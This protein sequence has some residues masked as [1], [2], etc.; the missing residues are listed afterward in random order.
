M[1]VAKYK[2]PLLLIP[3]LSVMDRYIITELIPPFLFGMG[4]FSAVGVTIG[5][6]FDLMRRAVDEGL[7]ATLVL[8]VLVLSLPQFI[9]YAFPTSILLAT[10]LTYSRLSSDSELTALRSCGVS[11]YRLVLPG[12]LLSLLVTGLTFL[13]NEQIVPAANYQATVTMERAL[14]E[15]KP[16][17]K[18]RNIFY[19]EYDS[20]DQEGNKETI[21]KRLF[22]A[23]QFDGERMRGLTI[24]DWSQQGL[25]QIVTAESAVWNFT[26]STWDFF[27]G[28]IYLIA[29]DASYR[30]ILR[31]THQQLQLPRTPLDLANKGRDYDEMNI[32]ESRERLKLERASGDED[33]VRKILIRIH[34]RIALPFACL[35]FGLVGSALGN[36]PQRT[37]KATGFGVSVLVIFIYYMLMAVGDALGLSNYL[38][39]IVAAWLPN[40][41]CLSVG[42][43]LLVKTAQ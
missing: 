2:S 25:N 37:N 14:N 10:L 16:P 39:P 31:F 24:L 21:L 42:G 27:N 4:M 18:E 19:R 38:P 29:P 20:V 32:A 23:Q 33:D 26:Q 36:S 11:I 1:T 7:P 41:L 17:F 9:A 6:L 35:V 3:G 8:K 15:E 22:Y 43:F 5:S 34:Q 12:I 30:N 13:F 40:L 28:T